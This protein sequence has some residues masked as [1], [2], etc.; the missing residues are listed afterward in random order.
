MAARAE[1]ALGI[2]VALVSTGCGYAFSAGVGRLPAG[3]GQVAVRPLAN[4]T[5]DADAGA[6]LGAALRAE[7]ARRGADGSAGAP[8]ALDGEV[9]ELT[10]VPVGASVWRLTLVVKARLTVAGVALA[11]QRVRRSEDY[12][13]G[14]DPLETE[15]RRRIA[16]QRAA[17]AAARELIDRMEE[18]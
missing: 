1:R 18:P 10:A 14:V 17:A 16:L 4:R 5:S 9:E 13:A 11:D 6:L 2:W 7:L 3:A 12:L 15:G 8:A